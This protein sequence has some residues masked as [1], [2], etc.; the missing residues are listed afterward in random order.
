MPITFFDRLKRAWQRV[1]FWQKNDRANAEIAPQSQDDHALVLAISNPKPAHGL[2]QIR[3]VNRV[4]SGQEKRI[5]W[6]AV[7]LLVV[8]AG[9]LATEIIRHNT[10]SSTY[11]RGTYI[12]AMNV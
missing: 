7:V 11:V 4:L 9:M 2:K 6:L 1:F 8:S 12:S 3:F 10:V 5:F